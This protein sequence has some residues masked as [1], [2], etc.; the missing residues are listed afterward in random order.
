MSLLRVENLNKSFGGLKATRNVSLSVA[1]QEL[2][3]IIGPNGAGKST[4][5]NQIS[6]LIRPDSGRVF[7]DDRDIT[8]MAAHRIVHLG[9]GRSFQRSNIFP[10]LTTFE[11]VEV[12][13][14]N[15]HRT[16]GNLWRVRKHFGQVK[17]RVEQ[18]LEHV[19]LQEKRDRLGGQLALGDQKRLE[20]GLAL[21]LEPKLLLLDEP[22]AGMS[23]EETSSTIGLIEK[24]VHEFK[25]SLLFTEHDIAMVFGISQHIR[26][27]HHG[28]I[29]AE[30]T[31]G[32]ISQN[33]E[34]QRIYL[35]EK[36]YGK[37][38]MSRVTG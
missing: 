2:S 24:L 26:V 29:V 37:R 3:S 38:P 12:A 32:E 16:G 15:Y 21:A 36:S 35:G 20:F 14:L 30:G 11:N 33:P 18:V 34:V 25:I 8:G 13:V 19:G 9:I 6:G 7:F 27:L 5:F 28:E 17:D 1:P 31:P 10:R 22:T 4:L 23:P